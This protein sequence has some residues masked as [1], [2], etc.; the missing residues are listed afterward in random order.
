LHRLIIAL[1]L[2][3]LVFSSQAKA[4]VKTIWSLTWRSAWT[5]CGDGVLLFESTPQT[6]ADGTQVSIAQR[7]YDDGSPWGQQQSIVIIGYHLTH[8][9][10]D[11]DWYSPT[12][13]L[14]FSQLVIGSGAGGTGADIFGK[15][16]GTGSLQSG[17]QMFPSGTGI[18]QGNVIIND[19][20]N[21]AHID[22]YGTCWIDGKRQM[23][24]ALIYY[25]TP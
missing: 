1:S 23:A 12:T 2:L 19:G 14:G 13:A 8:Y 15:V 6:M 7:H 4:Q 10:A 22:L 5:N 17:G 21:Y 25:T 20:N 24:E 3:A 11:Q 16:V 18:P 9:I